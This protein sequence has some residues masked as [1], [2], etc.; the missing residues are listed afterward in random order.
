MTFTK[1]P[2][3]VRTAMSG[4]RRCPCSIQGVPATVISVSCNCSQVH[5]TLKNPGQLEEISHPTP[6]CWGKVVIAGINCTVSFF[7]SG[8]TLSRG[9]VFRPII[10]AR[11]TRR[12]RNL[13]RF[14]W[15]RPNGDLKF[16]W[17]LMNCANKHAF[18]V[19]KR[20]PSRT[21]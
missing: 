13:G 2:V 8:P 10:R 19:L 4:I 15:Q 20:F 21:P 11:H 17:V 5:T 3:N 16:E 7:F 12:C 9:L 14:M 1:R 18:H 6:E